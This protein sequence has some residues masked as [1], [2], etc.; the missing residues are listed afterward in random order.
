MEK[1]R[2]DAY[3]KTK[4]LAESREQARR[5]IINS[6]VYVND[7]LT[8]KPSLNVSGCDKIEVKNNFEYVG[9]GALKLKKAIETFGIN[10]DNAVAVDIGAS[11]GG[12][13]DFLIKNNAKKVYAVDVG[14]GQLHESLKNHERVVN[15]EGINFRYVD[16]A[17]FK[18]SA[19]IV[20]VDV[21]FIS[22]KLILPKIAELSNDD[23]DIIIL[24][25]PQFEA[26]RQ[27]IGKNGI[28]KDRKIHLDVLK[29]IQQYCGEN[30]LHLINAAF[31]PIKGGDGNIEYLAHIKKGMPTGSILT[32]IKFKGL[33]KQAFE[34]YKK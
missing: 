12:F 23:T 1:Y 10:A 3:L 34:Y 27:N 24:V 31:S 6:F 29:S 15:L 33:I 13:T 32:E 18:E 2:L 20:T 28:V 19:D 11:T 8:V 26:G 9:R 7:K 30:G 17:I 14:H 21:S 16:T 25:K 4:G 22:L 5:L